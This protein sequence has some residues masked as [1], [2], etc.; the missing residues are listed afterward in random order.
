MF[1]TMQKRTLY[2]KAKGGELRV[3]SV[4]SEGDRIF[5]EYGVLGGA[6]QLSEK[7]AEG[8][9]IGRANETTPEQ[10][11]DLEANSLYTYKIERKYA[12]TPEKAKEEVLLPMLAKDLNQKYLKFACF[13]QP[14]LDGNRAL[15]FWEGDKVKL[16]SR[17][18]K[19]WVVPQHIN[20]ALEEIL[21]KATVLDG[22][23]YVHGNSCQTITSWVKKMRKET[24]LVQYHVY[25]MPEYMGNPLLSFELRNDYIQN[26]LDFSKASN[27]LIKVETKVAQSFEEVLDFEKECVENGY[28]GAIA[29]NSNSL[30]R[31]GFRSNDLL[32]VK[33]FED[34]EF[35]VVGCKEGRGKMAGK[36]V[37]SCANDLN[38]EIFDCSMNATMA[39]RRE[40]FANANKY[41]GA[42]LTVKHFGRTDKNLPRFPTGK[43]FRAIEDLS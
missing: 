4:W 8:K 31:Y 11:A 17:G 14:K 7:K 6:L 34:H 35:V 5:T 36:A 26:K 16:L 2:H 41:I 12:D 30:Y 9:N 39:E 29:R 40:F 13:V 10:Q 20:R 24:S 28:E 22:E 21:P 38:D 23:L 43:V 25:D 32:K 33:S 42:K 27:T 37:F 18:G 1:R 15:A 3:W 19:E